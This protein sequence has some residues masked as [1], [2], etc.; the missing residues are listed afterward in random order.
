MGAFLYQSEE[1]LANN[2]YGNQSNDA[3]HQFTPLATKIKAECHAGVLNKPQIQKVIDERHGLP[4]Q[5]IEFYP[6][7]DH[8]V[9]E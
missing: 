1:I 7:L 8:L 9:K 5:E 6:C 3:Q 4:M 2:E